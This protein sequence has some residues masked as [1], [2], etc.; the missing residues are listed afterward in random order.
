MIVY[1]CTCLC[2]YIRVFML[3]AIHFFTLSG[4]WRTGWI[5]AEQ[6]LLRTRQE[7][8]GNNSNIPGQHLKRTFSIKQIT[9]KMLS[10]DF[11]WPLTGNLK[12]HRGRCLIP[13][14]CQPF[15]YVACFELLYQGQI[16]SIHILLWFYFHIYFLMGLWGKVLKRTYSLQDSI[17]YISSL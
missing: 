9:P 16:P 5:T 6:P 2:Y 12:R 11:L 8:T 1:T 7:T 10:R 14:L 4:T 17:F 13:P 15:I 3:K